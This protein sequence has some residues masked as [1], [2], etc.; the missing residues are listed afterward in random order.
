MSNAFLEAEKT[1]LALSEVERLRLAE[2]VLESVY[3]SPSDAPSD[4]EWE[5]NWREE[6]ERRLALVDAGKTQM[7]S[8]E[9]VNAEITTIIEKARKSQCS[10]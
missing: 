3:G 7:H 9:S 1:V 4:E 2:R 10:S 6:I 5:E 8:W